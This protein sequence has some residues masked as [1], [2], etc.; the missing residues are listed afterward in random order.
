M[1]VGKRLLLGLGT[2]TLITA[3]PLSWAAAATTT[4]TFT[5]TA[6]V[7]TNCTINAQNL[8]FGSYTGALLDG[9]TTLTVDCSN[10]SAFNIGLSAGTAPGATV[11]T[12]KMTGPSGSDLLPYTLSRDSAHTLNWG[13]TVGTDTQAGTGTGANQTFTVFGEIPAGQFTTA[14]S[15]LDTITATLTF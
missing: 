3:A 6:N 1:R 4:A 9:T 12:R 8:N 5:V 10:G 13:N 15:Y 2:A 7:Q 11:S 14:G